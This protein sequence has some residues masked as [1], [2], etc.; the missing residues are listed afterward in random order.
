MPS[1][2]CRANAVGDGS[3]GAITICYDENGNKFAVKIFDPDEEDKTLAVGSLREVSIL[4]RIKKITNGKGHRNIINI[5]DVFMGTA[6][7]DHC[8]CQVMPLY[9]MVLDKIIRAKC[10]K[11][12][13]KLRIIRGILRG[14]EFMH[15]HNIMHRDIKP[16]NIL[17]DNNFRPIIVD[18]SLSKIIMKKLNTSEVN[19]KKGRTTEKDKTLT[20]ETRHSKAIG[21]P[22]YI[23]PE[24]LEG[25]GYNHK[26]D[27]YSIGVV[28]FELMQ[29]ELLNTTRD[30]AACT[31]I[32]SK[33]MKLK[34]NNQSH[35]LLKVLLH[36]DPEKRAECS[37]ALMMP[38][39]KEVE[40]KKSASTP[41]PNPNPTHK[42]IYNRSKKETDITKDIQDMITKICKCFDFKSKYTQ[43]AAAMYHNCTGE[44]LF[45]CIL[46]AQKMYEEDFM[47]ITDVVEYDENFDTNEY[48]VAEEN[49]ME[50]MDYDILL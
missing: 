1:K 14:V 39:F 33:L 26:C 24:V 45:Y 28:T 12:K 5:H 23:S 43:L 41:N 10:L 37:E 2:Y 8:L 48:S 46:L 30:K 47:D 11:K 16:E 38:V 9:Q 6:E 27:V 50:I 29:D 17:L 13:Q 4:N 44:P 18:F 42:Q 15:K 19:T 35:C 32:Q 22:T 36:L 31:F 21:T 25:D 3:Y 7:F 20:W 49:I 34:P 40:K